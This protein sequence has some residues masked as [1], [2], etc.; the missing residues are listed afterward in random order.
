MLIERVVAARLNEHL[1]Q[2]GYYECMQSAYKQHHSTESA[3]LKVQNDL[4]MGIDS[5]GG[6]FLVLLDLSAAFNTIDHQ[7][8]LKRLH[9]LEIRD[10]ALAWFRSTFYTCYS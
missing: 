8:L 4:L 7:I 9:K 5:D 6:A 2:N 10:H 3:L 1:T